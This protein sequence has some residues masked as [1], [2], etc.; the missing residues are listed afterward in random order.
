MRRSDREI[1]DIN[2]IITVM[3][4]CDVCRL[5][6]SDGDCPYIVPMNFGMEVCNE[7]ITLYFH[8]AAEGKKLDLI[9]SNKVA[10]F[11]MD[12]SHRLVTDEEHGNCTMEYESVIGRGTV[13]FVPEEQK[14]GALTCLMKHYRKGDFPFNKYI[15]SRTAV[16]KLTV[17]Q[18]TGKMRI[19]K[20]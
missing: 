16:F 8:S 5:A 14:F 9:R 4:K 13:E 17:K 12:C 15:I 1:T 20:H 11:E 19:K 10:S 2:K 6:F 7:E 18:L 3:E